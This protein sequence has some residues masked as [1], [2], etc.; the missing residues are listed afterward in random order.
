M[1]ELYHIHREIEIKL[2][3]ESFTNYLKLIGFLGKID[4]E[5]H[6]I[7]GFFDTEDKKLASDGWALRVRAENK[8]GLV[9]LKGMNTASDVASVRDEIEEEIPHGLA[10]EILDLK[11]DLLTLDIEPIRYVK[12][13]WGAIAVA[14]LVHFENNR[15]V[16]TF[17][18][19]DYTYDLLIDTT[20][21]SDGS[22]DY[23]LEVEIENE[24]QVEVVYDY[25]QKLFV[26]LNIPFQIQEKTKFLRA[27]E[28]ANLF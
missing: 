2:N 22:V 27:L 25:L 6:Q 5:E 17:K 24:Q 23:E 15:Q 14:K 7:N 19:G 3:L 13:T 18:I 21:F 10:L 9:T 12:D 28:R 20:H 16:K 4:G 11:Y 1:S 8:I 26:S